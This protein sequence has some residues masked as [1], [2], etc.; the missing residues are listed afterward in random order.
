MDS[1]S[2]IFLKDGK[3]KH[4]YRQRQFGE[5]WF[6]YSRL[7]RDM[8]QKFPSGS[9]FVEIGCWKGKSSAYMC[10]EIANSGKEIDFYCVDIWNCKIDL[11]VNHSQMYKFK[12]SELCELY[13]LYDVFKF[14]M[15]PLENYYKSMKITSVEASKK[16]EDNSIDFVF[17]DASHEYEDVKNDII[18]WMP[19]VKSGGILAGHDYPCTPSVYRAVNELVDNIE[20]HQMY[21]DCFLYQKP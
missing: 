21:Q 2:K 13:E 8:V 16:F 3:M 9:K 14:N 15:K 12:K 1:D 7:Y 6:T 18:S 19:K 17:I 11:R 4:I 10:V 5:N 20:V